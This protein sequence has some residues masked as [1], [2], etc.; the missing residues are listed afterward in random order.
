VPFCPIAKGDCPGRSKCPLWIR[1]RIINTD[2]KQLATRLAK[3]ILQNN[4]N[5][6]QSSNPQKISQQINTNFWEKEGIPDIK[7][8]CIRDRYLNQKVLEV[9]ALANKWLSSP[10]FRAAHIT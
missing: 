5:N 4:F 1:A 3:F 2:T 8:T 9:E 6:Q 10:A 7:Q